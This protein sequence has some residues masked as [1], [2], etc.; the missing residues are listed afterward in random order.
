MIEPYATAAIALHTKM[1]RLGF[2]LVSDA[3][4]AMTFSNGD[5][6]I[7]IATERNYHPSVLMSLRDPQGR[8]FELGTVEKILAPARFEEGQ[9]TLKLIRKQFGLD[10]PGTEPA[11]RVDGILEYA[12]AVLNQILDFMIDFREQIF[13]SADQYQEKYAAIE[14]AFL[15]NL[16]GRKIDS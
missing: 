4:Y 6:S 13:V 16:Q 7:D 3:D 2:K 14:H 15:A 11:V 9:I 8:R 5:Y 1:A 10:E 12:R